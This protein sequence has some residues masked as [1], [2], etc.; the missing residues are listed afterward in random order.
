M[1]DEN[2]TIPEDEVETDVQLDSLSDVEV[3]EM[4]PPKRP[5]GRPKGKAKPKEPNLYLHSSTL[6]GYH[7]IG[8][9]GVR[10]VLARIPVHTEYGQL[11]IKQHSALIHDYVDCGALSL[12]TIQFSL[13]DGNNREVDLRGGNI[14]CTLLF[15]QAPIV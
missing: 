9:M 12:R 2:K 4:P 8:P 6:T 13:R 3:E 1:T 11:I 15:A 5:R 7:S 10:S 14:S